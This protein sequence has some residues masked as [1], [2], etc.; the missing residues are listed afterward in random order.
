MSAS[1]WL[2]NTTATLSSKTVIFNVDVVQAPQQ[3][4]SKHK[5]NLNEAMEEHDSLVH[6]IPQEVASLFR[7]LSFV[8]CLCLRCNV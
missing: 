8:L 6:T 5:G 4:N 7:L 1:Y 3:H 2:H